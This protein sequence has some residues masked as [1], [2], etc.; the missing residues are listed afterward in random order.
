MN[1]F[2][3]TLQN[4]RPFQMMGNWLTPIRR[5]ECRNAEVERPGQPPREKR[6]LNIVG[7]TP[8]EPN[9]ATRCGRRGGSRVGIGRFNV[10]LVIGSPSVCHAFQ[11]IFAAV[12]YRAHRLITL[13][14]S[15]LLEASPSPYQT[16]RKVAFGSLLTARL[17]RCGFPKRRD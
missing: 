8:C 7:M 11:R 13:N 1:P 5:L 17:Q 14:A 15:D 3:F 10:A 2:E 6:P 9:H 12:F 4:N 16:G